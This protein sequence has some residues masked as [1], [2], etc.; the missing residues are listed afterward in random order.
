MDGHES[1]TAIQIDELTIRRAAAELGV[2]VR[3][4]RKVL[5]GEPV[6]GLAGLRARRAADRAR[7]LATQEAA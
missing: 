5:R 4:V 3:S 2:D 6:R 1:T 7:Q